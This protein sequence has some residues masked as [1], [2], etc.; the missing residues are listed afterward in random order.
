MPM[1]ETIIVNPMV[2]TRYVRYSGLKRAVWRTA[3]AG[4]SIGN[5][6]YFAVDSGARTAHLTPVRRR[7]SFSASL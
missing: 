1:M 5:S 6:R 2:T 3:G 4:V 7:S